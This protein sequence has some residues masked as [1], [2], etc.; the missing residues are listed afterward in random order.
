MVK[1]EP[2]FTNFNDHSIDILPEGNILMI[3]NDDKPGVIGLLGNVLGKKD[4]NINRLY[5][6]NQ[7]DAKKNYALALISVD[8]PVSEDVLEFIANMDEVK[9]IDQ[10]ILD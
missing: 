2:R 9:S 10:V 5:L 1:K 6:S 4:I 3:E 8:S 7:K